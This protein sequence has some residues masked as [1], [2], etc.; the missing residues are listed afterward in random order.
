MKV[1]SQP[2]IVLSFLLAVTLGCWADDVQMPKA[3]LSVTNVAQFRILSGAD[4]LEGCNFNLTG[5]V[6]LVDTTRDLVVLQDTTGSVA[7]NF[8]MG[9]RKLQV[10]QLVTIDGTNCCPLFSSFP[11]YPCRPSGWDICSSFETPS[12]WGEYNLTRMRGCV[13]PDVTGDYIFW[14][15]SDNS[16]ELWLSTDENPSEA[17]QICSVPRFGWVAPHEWS[18]FSTTAL[19]QYIWKGAKNI[20][21]K[22]CRSRQPLGKT[23]QSPGRGPA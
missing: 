20:I 14:I 8:P 4:Y 22:R 17:R 13:H 15:A 19:S 3:G 18:K 9:N 21:L 16:S 1:I 10:G 5:V 2:S 23:C 11:D 7:L 12:N 6:T